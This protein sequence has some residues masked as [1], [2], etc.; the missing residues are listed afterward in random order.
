MSQ[1]P[2]AQGKTF[3][4]FGFGAIQAGLFLLEAHASGAFGRLVDGRDLGQQIPVD[5]A[6][7]RLVEAKLF[8]QLRMTQ[9][10]QQRHAPTQQRPP[11]WTVDGR[12]RKHIVFVGVFLERSGNGRHVV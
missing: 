1:S 8:V 5:R 4:G 7:P 3:A 2:S 12:R 9:I 10:R 11:R 6:V